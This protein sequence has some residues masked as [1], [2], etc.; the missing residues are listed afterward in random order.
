MSR[1]ANAS[2]RTSTSTGRGGTGPDGAACAA[3]AA[4][5]RPPLGRARYERRP[6][7]QRGLRNNASGLRSGFRPRT[8]KTAEGELE[9]EIPE[10]REAAETFVSSLFPWARKLIATEPLRAMVIG[11]L[12]R[13]LAMRD[14][15]SLCEKAG[16]GKV[17]KPTARR[18]CTELPERYEQFNRRDRHEIR[19]LRDA[20]V[21]LEPRTRRCRAPGKQR[22]R[23]WQAAPV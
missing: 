12:V 2:S 9:I 11:A 17:A 1:I 4:L 10:V 15:E 6:E 5:L 13:G 19:L 20:R 16:L 23:A 14:V 8:V 22:L 3:G 7:Y 21:L 18:I